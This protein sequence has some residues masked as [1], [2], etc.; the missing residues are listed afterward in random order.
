MSSSVIH[1][2][3]NVYFLYNWQQ[4]AWLRPQALG[5]ALEPCFVCLNA[6]ISTIREAR[7]KNF[8]LQ[9]DLCHMLLQ[10][11]GKSVCHTLHSG[12]K[13]ICFYQAK[14]CSYNVAARTYTQMQTICVYIPN[15]K[16]NGLEIQQL[17]SQIFLLVVPCAA[18]RCGSRRVRL[19]L[20]NCAR[21]VYYY[22]YLFFFVLSRLIAPFSAV[23]HFKFQIVASQQ[24]FPTPR[25]SEKPRSLSV[26]EAE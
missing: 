9:L 7:D 20:N 3:K 17:G 18:P 12:R 15:F 4:K 13:V 8:G 14:Y 25:S 1:C 5:A 19:L 11:I 22:Y 2:A 23:T 6:Q 26:S 24:K 21:F 16:T 10:L